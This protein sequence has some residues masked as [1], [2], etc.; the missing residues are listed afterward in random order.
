MKLPKCKY[1]G[2]DIELAT[3]QGKADIEFEDHGILTLT[4][5][6]DY[7]VTC[8]SLGYS[9]DHK[10]IVAFIRA[11]G[12]QKLSECSGEIF[13]EKMNGTILRLIPLQT[14]QGEEFDIANLTKREG[15]RLLPD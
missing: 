7:G 10:F 8:Q 15:M 3:L 4:A 5:T 1:E 13:V 9:V 6:F 14:K 11:F 12:V 2:T